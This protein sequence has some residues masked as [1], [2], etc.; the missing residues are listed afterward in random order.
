MR[1]QK[2]TYDGRGLNDG[3][4]EYCSRIATFTTDYIGRDDLGNLLAAAPELLTALEGLCGL[5]AM[6]PGHLHEYKAAV[7][8]ARAAIAKAKGDKG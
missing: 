5:A 1:S 7:D 8:D 3:G 2:I 4:S 6:R